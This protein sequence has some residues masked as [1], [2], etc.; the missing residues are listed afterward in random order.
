MADVF[1]S[2][3]RAE[4]RR[5]QQ[6]FDLLRAQGFDVW[7]DAR[8]D[9][10]R[11]EGFDTEIDREVTSA[12][13]VIVC[14]TPEAVKSIY[15]K[16]EA[17]KGLEREVLVPVLLEPCTLP[18]PFNAVDAADFHGWSGEDKDE[19]WVAL[20]AKIKETVEKSR[21]DEE[22]RAAHSRAAYEHVADKIY[23]GTLELLSRRIAAR[24]GEDGHAYH[25][26]IA[27]LLAWIAATLEKEVGFN[28]SAYDEADLHC[29]GSTWAWWT[30]EYAPSRRLELTE[31]RAALHRIES[32]IFGSEEIFARPAP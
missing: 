23:P 5:V 20:Q 19:R 6:I 3:K 24:D 26:D 28:Q 4:R 25:G 16:A 22:H 13:C 10:G 8:L 1:I 7:F 30:R 18:V 29:G 32:A 27:A 17:K 14:W 9:L 15:V 21:A 2:Y 12:A 31:M 11:G